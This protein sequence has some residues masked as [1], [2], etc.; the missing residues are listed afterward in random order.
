MLCNNCGCELKSGE[1]FCSKC[2]KRVTAEVPLNEKINN[3]TE[4]DV[5]EEVNNEVEKSVA[6]KTDDTIVMP[7]VEESS[8]NEVEEESESNAVQ[9]SG[10]I[11]DDEQKKPAKK[12]KRWIKWSVIGVVIAIIAGIT[13]FAFPYIQNIFFRTILSEEEYF[14]HV[15]KNNATNFADSVSDDYVGAMLMYASG[16]G[17]H[18][19]LQIEVGNK[20]QDLIKE[21]AD[22][23]IDW[24]NTVQIS[25]V[26]GFTENEGYIDADIN[27]NGTDV[28]GVEL[29]MNSEATYLS[30]PGLSDRAIQWKSDE[31]Q[32]YTIIN[33][34]YNVAPDANV[35]RDL[36]VRY[37]MCLVDGVEDV[38][39]ENEVVKAGNIQKKYLKM[40]AKID[41]DVVSAGWK[42]VL[43]EAKNDPEIKKIIIDYCSATTKDKDPVAVYTDYQKSVDDAL[44]QI[45][46]TDFPEKFNFVIWVDMKGDIIGF[47]I[48][49]DDLKASYVNVLKGKKLGTSIKLQNGNLNVAFEGDGALKSKKFNGDYSLFVN[50]VPFVSVKL[51]N[52]DYELMK[53][54]IFNG[55]VVATASPAAVGM[56]NLSGNEALSLLANGKVIYRSEATKKH[57]SKVD[58]TVYSGN[59]L[60]LSVKK[61]SEK[62]TAQAP[63]VEKY[64]DWKKPLGMIDV[65]NQIVNNLEINLSEAG[66][67]YEVLLDFIGNFRF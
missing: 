35:L 52:L 16:K 30:L 53:K 57:E 12:K 63:K 45:D 65:A 28:T 33:E 18:S 23:N 49:A 24:L 26:S 7:V 44:A 9:E 13:A 54:N 22:V 5:V 41:G 59:D 46:A 47:G 27:I 38:E 40:T 34:L 58:L 64:T 6:E 25:S 42:K 55:Q 1:I 14:K 60:L 62:I 43:T 56:M 66:V 32:L 2:G 50:S 51:E 29:L 39:E 3:I 8:K 61:S 10:N 11:T 20:T 19:D 37:T 48:E 4:T 36:I 21:Y 15:I 31:V 17:T 67:P